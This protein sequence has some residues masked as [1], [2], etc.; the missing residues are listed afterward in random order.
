M[1]TFD[2][3]EPVEPLLLTAA[4]VADLLGV[5]TRTLWRLRSAGSVPAPVKLGGSVRWR[6]S[7]L[8]QWIDAGCPVP[9]DVQTA[10]VP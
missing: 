7:E 8:H 5:S 9:C 3:K 2:E 10:E 1:M 6:G 4:Q